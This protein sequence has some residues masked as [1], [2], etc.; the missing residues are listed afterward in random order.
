MEELLASLIAAK[1]IIVIGWFVLWLGI[2]QIWFVATAPAGKTAWKRWGR[3]AALFAGNTVL[4]P[5]LVLPVTLFAA[6]HGLS[7]RPVPDNPYFALAIDLILLDL[8]IYFWHRANHEVPF[9]WRFHEVHH[10]DEHLDATTAVRFHFGEVALSALVRGSVIF[11]LGVPMSSVIVFEIVVLL[12]AIFQHS[13]AR[14]PAQL[15]RALSRVIITPSLHWVHHHAVR[16][17]TDSTYGTFFSFWD[18]IFRSSSKTKRVPDMKIG[19]EGGQDFGLLA[20]IVAP[21]RMR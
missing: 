10:R 20:L 3:N 17:D 14:L 4:S 13:N 6:N 9:L 18:R 11:L 16:S 2:E 12:A 8:F 7:W 5:L 19:V 21:F 15:E 1:A